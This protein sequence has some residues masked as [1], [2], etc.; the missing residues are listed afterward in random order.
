MA[1]TNGYWEF[2]HSGAASRSRWTWRRIAGGEVAARSGKPTTTYGEAVRDAFNNGFEPRREEYFIRTAAGTT[3]F[4]PSS[5]RSASRLGGS[6]RLLHSSPGALALPTPARMRLRKLLDAA[7]SAQDASKGNVQLLSAEGALEIVA[8]RG[9]RKE[10]LQHF[11]FVRVEDDSACGRALRAASPVLIADVQRD[12]EFRPLRAIAAS[13]GFRA[14][15]SIP[16]IGSSGSVMG[17]LSVHYSAPL[18]FPEWRLTK[19]EES[20]RAI[21]SFF[22]RAQAASGLVRG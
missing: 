17:M 2:V 7:I 19:L 22:E 1:T 13:A 4:T 21:A 18:P 12:Q 5:G 14:V 10:F 8:Q 16:L 3:H 20:A 9:F 11:E 6:A 15:Q